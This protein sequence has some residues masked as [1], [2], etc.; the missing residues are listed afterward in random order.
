MCLRKYLDD[1]SYKFLTAVTVVRNLGYGHG[2]MAGLKSARFEVCAF[3]HAD[4]QC[5]PADVFCAF[6]VYEKGGEQVVKGRRNGRRIFDRLFSR[7]FELAARMILGR[8]ITEINAQPKVFPSFLIGDIEK[9]APK[10]FAFDIHVLLRAKEHNLPIREIQVSF[11][12]RAHGV[13]RWATTLRSKIRHIRLMLSYLWR[14]R[15]KV[16]VSRTE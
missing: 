11:P 13:S 5:E 2:L 6:A 14:A 12:P 7:G 15:H 1:P 9:D 10:D 4:E 3:S 8:R 16:L